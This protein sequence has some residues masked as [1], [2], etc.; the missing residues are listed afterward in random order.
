VARSLYRKPVRNCS[1]FN[2]S[3]CR[4]A[5]PAAVSKYRKGNRHLDRLHPIDVEQLMAQMQLNDRPPLAEEDDG[6]ADGRPKLLPEP[7]Q[8]S[9]H[10][11]GQPEAF[12][13]KKIL[14]FETVRGLFWSS[15]DEPPP[16]RAY[17]ERYYVVTQLD[18]EVYHLAAEALQ[19]ATMVGVAFEGQ[20]LGRNGK[21][22]TVTVATR[23]AAFVFDAVAIGDRALIASLAE[24]FEGEEVMKVMH[25]CR[26]PADMLRHCY[27]VELTNVYDTLA[28]HLHHTVWSVYAGYMCAYAVPV[29]ALVRCYFGVK[30]DFL[31][32]VRYRESR[33]REDT[34]V[35]LKRPMA[36]HL[37]YGAVVNAAYLLDLQKA[38]REC[39]TAPF[40]RATRALLASAR[41]AD[42]ME[43]EVQA[44]QPHVVPKNVLAC[45][46][47]LR[48]NRER[49][50]RH[51]QVEEKARRVHQVICQGDTN[52]IFS[53]DT[54]HQNR[55]KSD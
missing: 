26:Q 16:L 8:D 45:L 3:C 51:G 27:G 22:S 32:Y 29:N 42:D 34:A 18:G 21:L 6:Q 35:W 12:Q 9:R 43:A 36:P 40:V 20:L 33:L 31:F 53:R 4:K 28:A 7:E 15:Q 24:L 50:E 19:E 44:K 46:P 48:P 23:K 13:L 14:E 47:D 55:P 54:M 49:A 52:L 39:M 11:E 1:P 41:D 38:T 30:S 10:Q 5:S 25:D 37:E 2:S 17:P